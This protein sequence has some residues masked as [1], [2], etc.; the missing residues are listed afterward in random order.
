MKKIGFILLAA[1]AAISLSSCNETDNG[2][3][4]NSSAFALVKVIAGNDY[5]LLLDNGKTVFPSDK[6][7]VGAYEA[8][9]NQRVITYLNLLDTKVDGYD[10][11]A[12]I[13]LIQN[14]Y[15]N[16]AR[17]ID[18]QADL[19][20]LGKDKVDVIVQP[21]VQ[22]IANRKYLM[23]PVAYYVNNN[24]KHKFDLIINK[25]EEPGTKFEDYLSVELRHNADGETQGGVGQYWISFD[26]AALQAEMVGMKGLTLRV[27]SINSGTRY[28]KIELPKEQ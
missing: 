7:R 4:A 25:V 2:D 17:I 22:P 16:A 21:N 27:E 26:L 23:L 6:T 18:Q 8:K 3:Y 24:S 9:D 5:Y 11:S 14:I 28:V 19:N 20:L 10:Y 13:Y 12:A 15:S 1:V